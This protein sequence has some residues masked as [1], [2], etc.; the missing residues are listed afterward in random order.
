MPVPPSTVFQ[1]ATTNFALPDSSLAWE[2]NRSQITGAVGSL[3]GT[4]M[5]GA[6]SLSAG[7]DRAV[8]ILTTSPNATDFAGKVVILL[9]DG[10]WNDG[11]HPIDAAYD[12]KEAGVIVHCVLMLTDDQPDIR[13]VAEITGGRYYI[14]QNEQELREAFRE[15][16]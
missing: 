3:G 12:A 5:M 10:I 2:V 6:T 15:L 16:A 9:T 11:P 13:Q 4:A 1:A 7:L 8:N 14:T